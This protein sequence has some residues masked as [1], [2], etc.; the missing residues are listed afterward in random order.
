MARADVTSYIANSQANCRRNLQL[1]FAAVNPQ[2][3]SA[4]P[5]EWR[6]VEKAIAEV[7]AVKLRLKKF[8]LHGDK[9]HC[10]H[11]YRNPN[12][13]FSTL[14]PIASRHRTIQL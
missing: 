3:C 10:L 2:N 7:R 6:T 4:P 11:A 13:F 1:G 14:P 8:L 5:R 12:S 9:T